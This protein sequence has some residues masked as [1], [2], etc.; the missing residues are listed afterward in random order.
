MNEEEIK[1]F[2]L[3]KTYFFDEEKLIQILYNQSYSKMYAGSIEGS[4]IIFPV[5]GETFDI[6]EEEDP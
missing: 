3:E 1:P 6:E 4:I 5:E 2:K